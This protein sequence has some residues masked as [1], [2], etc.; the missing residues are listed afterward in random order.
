MTS[1]PKDD[2]IKRK[3]E[4]SHVTKTNKNPKTQEKMVASDLKPL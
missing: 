3:A 2:L 4:P 1:S